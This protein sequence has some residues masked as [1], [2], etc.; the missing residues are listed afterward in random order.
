MPFV[1]SSIKQV[2]KS[3]TVQGNSIV[4]P[5]VIVPLDQPIIWPAGSYPT[6]WWVEVTTDLVNWST[7]PSHIDGVYLDI[8]DPMYGTGVMRQYRAAGNE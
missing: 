6:S 2:E 4:V 1:S 8:D 3:Q 7:V 5:P